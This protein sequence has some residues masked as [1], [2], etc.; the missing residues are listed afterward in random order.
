V[1]LLAA[2]GRRDRPRDQ[3]T[4]F[5]DSGAPIRRATANLRD[6]WTAGECRQVQGA[7]ARN[8]V[9]VASS[10]ATKPCSATSNINGELHARARNIGGLVGAWPWPSRPTGMSLKRASPRR[11]ST[12]SRATSA[13]S[14]AGAQVCGRRKVSRSGAA[15]AREDRSA[16]ARASFRTN[17]PTSKYR[18]FSY[19]A[20]GVKSWR[21]HVSAPEWGA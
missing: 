16:C 1:K 12:T 14:S 17:G 13:S 11:S 10:P 8:V 9:G 18:R 21:S 20:F 2:I 6:W 4:D 19:D 3:P 5:D 7:R 15:Q